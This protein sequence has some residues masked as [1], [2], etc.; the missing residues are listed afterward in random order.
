MYS[1]EMRSMVGT[2]A[3]AAV[4]PLSGTMRELSDVELLLVS[5]AWDWS[6]FYGAMFVGAVGGAI[7]GAIG[8]GGVGALPG[9]FAGGFAGGGAYAANQLW[10]FLISE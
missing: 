9:A 4:V 10:L 6:D 5:G 7:G 3:S 1:V 2:G 8:G